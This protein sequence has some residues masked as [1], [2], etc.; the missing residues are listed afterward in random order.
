MS[1]VDQT[2]DKMIAAIEH[3]KT[4]LKTFEQGELIREWLN[5]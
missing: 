2:K 1:I 4:E 3:F 5:M